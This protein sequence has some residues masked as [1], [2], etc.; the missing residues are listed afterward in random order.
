MVIN[1][2][3]IRES[4]TSISLKSSDTQHQE[5]LNMLLISDEYLSIDYEELDKILLYLH[6]LFSNHIH[7][8]DHYAKSF[9]SENIDPITDIH[10]I[11]IKLFFK[12]FPLACYHKY[13]QTLYSIMTKIFSH[14]F[15][16]NPSIGVELCYLIISLQTDQIFLSDNFQ[17]TN[18]NDPKL[19]LLNTAT[20]FLFP[21]QIYIR[22]PYSSVID[23]STIA[24]S[25]STWQNISFLSSFILNLLD[26]IFSN[27]SLMK[28]Q[29]YVCLLTIQSSC[30]YLRISHPP[31]R[32]TCIE[33]L[34]I[35]RYHNYTNIVDFDIGQYYL[36]S[37]LLQSL[38]PNYSFFQDPNDMIQLLTMISSFN[39]NVNYDISLLGSLDP[40]SCFLFVLDSKISIQLKDEL[41]L[42]IIRNE[43]LFSWSNHDYH[44]YTKL[45]RMMIFSEFKTVSWIELIKRFPNDHEISKL[46]DC[47]Y[48]RTS[49]DGLLILD[50]T[51][52]D[53]MISS[54]EIYLLLLLEHHINDQNLS[55]W[56]SIYENSLE[57]SAD[58]TCRILVS[59]LRVLT[60]AI[61]REF[62][63][64]QAIRSLPTIC[65]KYL[66]TNNSTISKNSIPISFIVECISI[67][68]HFWAL[69]N[70]VDHLHIP[71][72]L[73]MSWIT[74]IPSYSHFDRIM[75]SILDIYSDTPSI[76]SFFISHH[77]R[78]NEHFDTISHMEVLY[79]IAFQLTC[80]I[81]QETCIKNVINLLTRLLETK[82]D[83]SIHCIIKNSLFILPLLKKIFKSPHLVISCRNEIYLLLQQDYEPVNSIF[84][85]L[86]H[87]SIG[88]CFASMASELISKESSFNIGLRL[89][90]MQFKISQG[91]HY[92]LPFL[93][94][95]LNLIDEDHKK[96]IFE[97]ILKSIKIYKEWIRISLPTI[98]HRLGVSILTRPK[99][100]SFLSN[101]L[102]ISTLSL[103]KTQIAFIIP[104]ITSDIITL[105]KLASA[106]DRYVCN[107]S[108]SLNEWL[109]DYADDIIA[110]HLMNG[111]WNSINAFCEELL[112]AM[113]DIDTTLLIR[114]CSSGIIFKLTMR[115]CTIMDDHDIEKYS[116]SIQRIAIIIGEQVNMFVESN[117]FGLLNYLK[118]F[119]S[120]KR[121]IPIL[122][123]RNAL[124]C[125]SIL[126]RLLNTNH[127]NEARSGFDIQ[128]WSI[129]KSVWIN[130]DDSSDIIH[131]LESAFCSI[132]LSSNTIDNI[133]RSILLA[134]IFIFRFH[135][136]GNTNSI[137]LD[138]FNILK[139]NPMIA[140]F[141]S[142]TKMFPFLNI[143]IDEMHDDSIY[144]EFLFKQLNIAVMGESNHRF[145]YCT[146]ILRVCK[147]IFYYKINEFNWIMS[148]RQRYI[149]QVLLEQFHD[150]L[151]RILSEQ[152][153]KDNEC[154]ILALDCLAFVQTFLFDHKTKSVTLENH[155]VLC[156]RN[157][158]KCT[159][160][161]WLC[162]GL[163]FILKQHLIPL[164]HSQNEENILAYLL[165]EYM[166]SWKQ[167][168]LDI[169]E[170][171]LNNIMTKDQI[172]FLQPFLKSKYR[173]LEE[174]RN[175]YTDQ[176]IQS[177]II[178]AV[179]SCNELA[180]HNVLKLLV[181]TLKLL[182]NIFTLLIDIA[183]MI[184][185][186]IHCWG[187]IADQVIDSYH[188]SVKNYLNHPDAFLFD[189]ILRIY[190]QVFIYLYYHI[191]HVAGG[192]KLW[193]EYVN[194]IPLKEIAHN[195]SLIQG[196]EHAYRCAFYVDQLLWKYKHSGLNG[197]DLNE[198]YFTL[199]KCEHQIGI[200]SANVVSLGQYMNHATSNISHE[201]KILSAISEHNHRQAILL[202]EV[203]TS[204]H[205]QLSKC[206]ISSG[207]SEYAYYLGKCTDPNSEEFEKA[208]W[209]LGHWNEDNNSGFHGILGKLMNQVYLGE[210][211]DS[212]IN[213]LKLTAINE[214]R[215]IS[216][217]VQHTGY[218]TLL[219][220]VNPGHS[221]AST[222]SN[223]FVSNS[224]EKPS[225]S[226]I[227]Q[228]C[229]SKDHIIFLLKL[230]E[231]V[232][233]NHSVILNGW[234]RY[235][236][237]K[238]HLRDGCIEAAWKQS[239]ILRNN[240]CLE[241]S[242]ELDILSNFSALQHAKLIVSGNNRSESSK[243]Q[244]LDYLKSVL[245]HSFTTDHITDDIISQSYK[246]ILAKIKRT[247]ATW[248]VEEKLFEPT[249]ILSM[250][251]QS[252]Q[253]DYNQEK[254][255]Y[256]LAKY[257]LEL[258]DSSISTD[259]QAS[260]TWLIQSCK[261]FSK[262]IILGKNDLIVT[263]SIHKLFSIWFK[264]ANQNETFEQIHNDA[265]LKMLKRL[266][267]QKLMKIISQLISRV[268]FPNPIVSSTLDKII[269]RLFMIF[270]HQTIWYCLPVLKS[271]VPQ[272]RKR[273]Q[274]DWLSRIMNS[275]ELGS[276]I[277]DTL[278]FS[279]GLIQLANYQTPGISSRTS[280]NI[281]NIHD[282]CL[283]G[284]YGV[285]SKWLTNSSDKH[286]VSLPRLDW[287]QSFSNDNI[288]II[289]IHSLEDKVNVMPSLQKPKRLVMIGSDGNRYIFLCKPKDD[290]RKDARFMEVAVI[291]NR[292]LKK[293]R[294]SRE[295]NLY[296]RPYGVYPLNEECGILEWVP[297][298]IPYRQILLEKY[299]SKNLSTSNRQLRDIINLPIPHK[300]I[301][302]E[303]LLPRFPSVFYEWFY[304]RF[305]LFPSQHQSCWYNAR[306][307][308]TRT[309]A[310][311][312]MFGYV[313]GLGDRH[314]ENILLDLQTGDCV[315]VDFNCLF[316]KGLTFEKPE[317]VPFRLTHNIVDAMHP[318]LGY[319]GEFRKSCE[320]T[321]S[322]LRRY[323]D[324]LLF[325]L[326]TFV[327]DPLVEWQAGINSKQKKRSGSEAENEEG[328]K[329]LSL[330]DAKLNG[331]I[332]TGT[333]NIQLS[334]YGQVDY[335]IREA[336]SVNNLSQMYVGWAPFM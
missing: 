133:R 30:I 202:F 101:L 109:I 250:F 127:N 185:G 24:L 257:Q 77:Q 283:G 131:N 9:K 130:H 134:S 57:R 255:F 298:L 324:L 186:Y 201:S 90:F 321:L 227:E 153:Q 313:M 287:M 55:K 311:M 54:L 114:Y 152:S 121:H 267:P 222:I 72:T 106:I 251:Q 293:H 102:E 272:R 70:H 46:N 27:P 105:S 124:G 117:L 123:K 86:L 44:V 146:C 38:I 240:L 281:L 174:S 215:D 315:H 26:Y 197:M 271:L 147:D 259:T 233:D 92:G 160:N 290:L 125:M 158:K 224:F 116:D 310:V 45:I 195:Y 218:V 79:F 270:P 229:L 56:I 137:I 118:T 325:V 97:M 64:N 58:M 273:A 11:L 305:P 303:H 67:N 149:D 289:T 331:F 107:D 74:C 277:Q 138:I 208:S 145:A 108:H 205:R 220:L 50:S 264:T 164:Y 82:I 194:R 307:C 177:W 275:T 333:S 268:L 71:Y 278:A 187:S 52:S 304:E 237:V 159:V 308:Y 309:M 223:L 258:S 129:I 173:L 62:P 282:T 3:N 166:I 119:L 192:Y 87:P 162:R 18:Q 254:T 239:L 42:W 135:H 29:D 31:S 142:D 81:D 176:S 120:H 85:N 242:K 184:L 78:Y 276:M 190:D 292:L 262:A 99:L 256:H 312:S 236:L 226:S 141:L 10:R 115:Y 69:F 28:E 322:I 34:S 94:L 191:G 126:G 148:L 66:I 4:H 189:V 14:L 84:L 286:L 219:N 265:M 68:P 217:L 244:A 175:G 332:Q 178:R 53:N 19:Q 112:S 214:S 35:S 299:E 188:L 261:S 48:T 196:T 75:K 143:S 168:S 167:L 13:H 296:M 318:V 266:E 182:P 172:D 300:E 98:L 37:K 144:I 161:E 136:H 93:L 2:I 330:I 163:L 180:S 41:L 179:S 49:T 193:I 207:S 169:K 151:I 61:H 33:L 43:S 334:I 319:D 171:I 221:L 225:A 51:M 211:V 263:E 200:S 76:E 80:I 89:A 238:R 326:E 279:D 140:R 12:L 230:S 328:K 103:F 88:A 22:L 183:S 288:G 246:S 23:V 234:I 8:L 155:S 231:A 206:L 260:K 294:D 65:I 17:N 91:D 252:I 16:I 316:E 198:L 274:D 181:L 210:D 170:D 280:D 204:D 95:I 247:M 249:E 327:H 39:V 15:Y 113:N 269:I 213:T 306:L 1:S 40:L 245:S 212:T 60:W 165:Q 235:Q 320:V 317:L 96:P 104:W 154:F 284:R 203:N 157:T 253:L 335:L 156:D 25:F 216:K 20:S 232:N 122:Q 241:D 297:N 336:T 228:Q 209:Q 243:K 132:F 47:D 59:L 302:L 7:E 139:D 6:R 110:F 63:T 5:I 295:L 83:P 323:R 248:M 150:N 36:C 199:Q 285:L 291:L 301:Y 32:M 73:I 21:T 111:N 100:V 128:F 329:T 314:G